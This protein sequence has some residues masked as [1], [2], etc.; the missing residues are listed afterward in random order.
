MGRGHRLAGTVIRSAFLPVWPVDE[1]VGSPTQMAVFER[2]EAG[3]G[4]F[5]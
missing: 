3:H 1:A 4:R 2:E 5:P